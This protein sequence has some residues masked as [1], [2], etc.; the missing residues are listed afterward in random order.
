VGNVNSF[1][2][3]KTNPPFFVTEKLQQNQTVS[4]NFF[5]LMEGPITILLQSAGTKTKQKRV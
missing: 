1:Q 3:P 5:L 2:S 4:S